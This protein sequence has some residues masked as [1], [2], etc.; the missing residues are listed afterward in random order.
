MKSVYFHACRHF[1]SYDCSLAICFSLAMSRNST[2]LKIGLIS[3]T[4]NVLRPQAA[5]ALAG[6]DH[7]LHAGDICDG[8]VL[9]Q[10]A[11]I[12]PVTAV[13]GNND[14]GGWADAL[15]VTEM[16]E[17][18]GIALYMIHDVS[19]LDIDPEAAGVQAV[20][21]GHSH[22]PLIEQRD[23]VLFVNPGS[24][25]PRRFT[26]PVSLGFLD[27]ADGKV[28]ASLQTLKI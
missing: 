22:R 19:E 14:R 16:I 15:R 28:S 8:E 18:G 1:F 5:E 21:S 24:A 4:H 27:I 7:I 10:L 20:I 3:D 9:V 17:F 6:V 2:S 25:G 11:K 12:A 26:L 23:G 13:R